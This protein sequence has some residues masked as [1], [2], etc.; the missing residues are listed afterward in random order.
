MMP[1]AASH[2][3]IKICGLTTSD[4]VQSII[5]AKADYAGFV[6]FP[7]SPR[8]IA[9][10]KAVILK[11]LL[12]ASI[13]AVSVLVDPDDALLAQVMQVLAPDFLQLHGKETPERV[14]TI[15][16]TFP[17]AKLIK[18]VQVRSSDDIAHA[19]AFTAHIDGLLFDA[20]PPELPGML[21]GGNGLSFDWALLK[22]REFPLPWFLS[23][24]LNGENIA[25][26]LSQSGAQ[27]IDISSGVE[28]APGVKDPALI[29]AFIHKVRSI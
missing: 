19:M 21:P 16:A 17:Q 29:E 10:D 23:G 3:A 7:A 25:D 15:R 5:A 18:A 20:K 12:P 1:P 28:S 11:T 13:K 8:H 26:A 24:G 2:I 9:L 27:M 22:N 6:Y 14:K 4:A